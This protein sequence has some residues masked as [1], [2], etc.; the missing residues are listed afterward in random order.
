M[1]SEPELIL[2][3]FYKDELGLVV[4]AVGKDNYKTVPG[5][6]TIIEKG[7]IRYS[8]SNEEFEALVPKAVYEKIMQAR[9]Q[10]ASKSTDSNSPV[11]PEDDGPEL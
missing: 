8:Y 11:T 1:E 5:K 2:L 7:G 9:Q 4:A 10:K 6:E 3:R